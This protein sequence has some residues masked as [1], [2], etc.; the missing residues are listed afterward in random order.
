[1]LTATASRDFATRRSEMDIFQESER[2]E[3]FT[4]YLR[5]AKDKNNLSPQ[6]YF[7][8]YCNGFQNWMPEIMRKDFPS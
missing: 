4:F 2:P 7:K 8:K 1:M 3:A 5:M 6:D